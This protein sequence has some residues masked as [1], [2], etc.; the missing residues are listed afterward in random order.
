MA[1]SACGKGGAPPSTPGVISSEEV[2]KAVTKRKITCP[3]Q[4]M[5]RDPG[6]PVDDILGVR[7]GE[8]ANA[9]VA[10]LFCQNKTYSP[11]FRERDSYGY[12][13]RDFLNVSLGKFSEVSFGSGRSKG[14]VLR[15]IQ[16]GKQDDVRFDKKRE[17]VAMEL[18]GPLGK[19]TVRSVSRWQ[20]FGDKPPA[21]SD[22]TAQ[23]FAKY[24]QPMFVSESYN[25]R[26]YAWAY[27]VDGRPMAIPKSEQSPP[28]SHEAEECA[29]NLEFNG[30]SDLTFSGFEKYTLSTACG[31]TIVADLIL[32]EG[33]VLVNSARVTS[34][35]QAASYEATTRWET[36]MEAEV[37]AHQQKL[38][39]A[40]AP[41]SGVK[42]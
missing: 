27:E 35:N 22:V 37:K 8:A 6:K 12:K 20:L 7:P 28:P 36:Q 13:S 5:A 34:T 30:R 1:L 16:E 42:F 23:L 19:E 32:L 29:S 15:G 26:R 9:A 39:T 2:E 3:A 33:G 25:R 31:V 40:N 21:L 18:D 41:E 4:S 14:D 10:I 24:G 11:F 38:G 17:R